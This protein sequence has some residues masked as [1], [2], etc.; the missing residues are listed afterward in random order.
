MFFMLNFKENR[1]ELRRWTCTQIIKCGNRG[2]RHIEH[3]AEAQTA[4]PEASQKR[5]HFKAVPMRVRTRQKF[6]EWA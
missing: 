3:R 4:L 2:R 1:D 6:S 5:F